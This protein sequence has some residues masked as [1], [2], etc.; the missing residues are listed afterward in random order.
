MNPNIAFAVLDDEIVMLMP[1]EYLLEDDITSHIQDNIGLYCGYGD[2]YSEED[3]NRGFKWSEPDK[4]NIV[5]AIHEAFNPNKELQLNTYLIQNDLF[6]AA[7]EFDYELMEYIT[8]QIPEAQMHIDKIQIKLRNTNAISFDGKDTYTINVNADIKSNQTLNNSIPITVK[9][10]YEIP[11]DKRVELV[12]FDII[13]TGKRN[14]EK[15]EF[16]NTE[17]I[18]IKNC[19]YVEPVK[20]KNNNKPT[21]R[22]YAKEAAAKLDS[23]TGAI[24]LSGLLELFSSEE[25]DYIGNV[26]LAEI[27]MAEAPKDTLKQYLST[28]VIDSLFNIDSNFIKLA[29]DKIEFTV[30]GDTKYGEVKLKL[31]CKYSKVYFSGSEFCFTGSVNYEVVGGEG[32]KKLPSSYKN[33]GLAGMF[34]SVDMQSFCESAYK[35]F[36]CHLQKGVDEIWGN[37]VDGAADLIFG[38]IVNEILA[39]TEL[40]SVSNIAFE[41]IAKP[42]KSVLISCP[43]D[44]YVYNADNELVAAVVGNEVIK[45]DEKAKIA[46]EGDVKKVILLDDSYNIVYRAMADGEMKVTVEEYG[47]SGGLLNSST[48]SKVSLIAGRKYT[49]SIDDSFMENSDYAIVSASGNNYTPDKEYSTLAGHDYISGIIKEVTCQ[50]NGCMI[51]TCSKCG[52]TYTETI[53]SNGHNFNEGES[54]CSNC[55]YDRADDCGCKCHKTGFFAKLI[56]KIINFFNKILRKQQICECN[57]RHW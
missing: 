4:N 30:A 3:Y 32:A 19:D 57:I 37:D 21:N 36:E 42:G 17:N 54:K 6:V 56:W 33:G 34:S 22:Q 1:I 15:V 18:E 14:G 29:K 51:H 48:I 20:D 13:I 35:L 31:I 28:K 46:V 52:D 41:L 27:A 43:V 44:V 39:E 55:D 47:T 45:T 9:S 24:T 8:S 23:M 5:Y 40:K 38:T 25:L 7:S 16:T 50:E 11:E 12:L 49:Q 10:E 2:M 26:I 53:Q